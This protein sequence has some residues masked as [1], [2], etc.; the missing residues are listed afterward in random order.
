MEIGEG[1]CNPFQFI[2]QCPPPLKHRNHIHVLDD[3]IS[4][5]EDPLVLAQVEKEKQDIDLYIALQVNPILFYPPLLK[6]LKFHLVLKKF[7]LYC[8]FSFV[9]S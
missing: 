2:Q 4:T 8:K 5:W 9:F 3:Q 6:R 1:F 7:L